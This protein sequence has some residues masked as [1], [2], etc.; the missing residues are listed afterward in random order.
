MQTVRM[1][2][3]GVDVA[4]LQALLNKHAA[5]GIAVDGILGAKQTVPAL[6][7]YQ[8]RKSLV[9]DGIAGPKTWASFGTI[10]EIRHRVALRSQSG[11]A[12]CWSAAAGMVTGV[13]QSY[14]PGAAATGSGGGLVP[15]LPNVET[16]V[17]Q[18]H[19]H[20]KNRVSAPPPSTLV[21]AMRRSPVWIAVGGVGVP[22]N[23]VVVFSAVLSDGDESGDGTAFEVQDPWPM[24]RGTSYATGYAQRKLILRSVAS[25]P[26]TQIMYVAGP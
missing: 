10:E 15:T 11:V 6:K 17:A 25:H 16:F 8:A 21:S 13:P 3:R 2:S 5:A 9:A 19:W 7:A 22:V 20:I 24:G 4:L 23:H 1:G 26:A 14:G 12:G 18:Q